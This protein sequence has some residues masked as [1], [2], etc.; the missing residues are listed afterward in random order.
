MKRLNHSYIACGVFF[1]LSVIGQQ[2]TLS[3]ET[4]ADWQ[5]LKRDGDNALSSSNYGVAERDLTQALT[6]AD[7]FGNADLRLADTLCSLAALY[8]TRGQFTK[9][10]PF[11][12]RELRVRE[13]AIGGENP[14]V[15]ALVGKLAQFYLNHGSPQKAD[16]LCTLLISFADRRVKDQQSVKEQFG[17]L[18]HYYDKSKGY[19]EAQKILVKLKDE[20][21]RTTADEN[22]ELAATL[23][24]LAAIYQ[25][26]HKYDI[27]ERMYKN[28]LSFREH[29]LSANHLALAYSYENLANLYEA[30]GKSEVAEPYFKRSL[31]ITEK[32][33]QPGRAEFYKRLDELAQSHISMGQT[34]QAE[35]LYKHAL[36][37]MDKTS[38]RGDQGKA[39]LALGELYVKEGRYAQAEPLMKR[40]LA[41]AEAE[42]GPHHMAVAVILDS[43]A[44]VLSKLSKSSEAAHLRERARS[45]RGLSMNLNAEKAEA[46][47]KTKTGSNY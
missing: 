22:L 46:K 12:E 19:A 27:A 35:S 33:L 31:E 47:T 20:T 44:D 43:Y 1:L 34:A 26:L 21:E 45:I 3:A 23:D 25:G 37:L 30:Q 18:D 4:T 5:T 13:K 9:A 32:I 2:A 8:S 41:D 29:T 17:K 6:F 38:S 14:Q 40:A 36:T 42:K 24:S 39:S 7:K 16:H 28:A 15:V 10:Q 11:Y